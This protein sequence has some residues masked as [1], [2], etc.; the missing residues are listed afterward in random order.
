MA[1]KLVQ[2]DKLPPITLK[3][4]DGGTLALPEQLPGRY[5]ALLFYRGHWCP[6]CRRHLTSYQE[7]LAEL[8]SL[9]VS[10]VAASVDT[11]EQSQAVVSEL[12]LTFP[13]AYGVSEADVAEMDPWIGVRENNDRYIQP[14]ELLVLRG[15]TIFGSLYG[16]GPVGRMGV[17]EVLNSVHGREKRRMEQERAHAETAGTR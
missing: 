7:N 17:D 1:Q 5:L 2:G 16:S 6:Y 4:T 10:V 8:T 15:G 12:G 13:V 9:S 3:L 14:M 11:L